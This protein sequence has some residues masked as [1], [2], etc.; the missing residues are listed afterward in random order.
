M[1]INSSTAI[2]IFISPVM[3]IKKRM[4]EGNLMDKCNL[5]MLEKVKMLAI[6]IENI[7]QGSKIC[8]VDEENRL[9]N[10]L[11]NMVENVSLVILDLD[12]KD[13]FAMDLINQVRTKIESTPIVVLTQ[14]GKKEFFVEA[15]LHGATDFIIKP[16]LDQTFLSKVYKYTAPTKRSGP[17]LVAFSLKQY[18]KGELRKAEKGSFPL[19]IMF[20][21][22]QATESIDCD[23][24]NEYLFSRFKSLFWD[25]DVLI[26][27]A[28]EYYL[29]IF[30]F[31]DEKNTEIIGNK[32]DDRLIQIKGKMKQYNSYTIKKVF[33]SYPYDT[34]DKDKVFGL[35]INRIKEMY[36][37]DL[38]E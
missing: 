9:F 20:L 31:C 1:K 14:A 11:N 17:E 21:S 27:F 30:P 29:G 12:L 8:V 37:I 13:A 10:S 5:L 33:A 18:I 3:R 38:S 36:Q 7:L 24:E 26:S 2:G 15:I 23:I 19:S 25:T 32:I 35:L 28:S 6:R 34:P 16:F 22:F 4:I